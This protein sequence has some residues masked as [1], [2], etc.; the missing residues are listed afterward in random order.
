MGRH[1]FVNRMCQPLKIK[2]VK[3]RAGKM[4]TLTPNPNVIENKC[5]VNCAIY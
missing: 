4:L 2:F 5:Q 3:L 1:K